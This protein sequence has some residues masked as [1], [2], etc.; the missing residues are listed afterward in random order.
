MNNLLPPTPTPLPP[1]TAA[2]IEVDISLWQSAPYAI[3]AWNTVPAAFTTIF[4]VLIILMI[5]GTLTI[6]AINI[7]N[8]VT[9]GDSA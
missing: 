6:L 4:Q 8:K 7:M 2:P 1:V 5:V 9:G 3:Q